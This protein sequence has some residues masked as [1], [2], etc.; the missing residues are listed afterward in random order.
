MANGISVIT[1]QPNIVQ[2]VDAQGLQLEQVF[3][4]VEYSDDGTQV[5]VDDFTGFLD[6]SGHIMVDGYGVPMLNPDMV[7][8]DDD[9]LDIF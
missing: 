4:T 7:D 3:D 6:N 8:L 5:E 2:A 9:I 1:S